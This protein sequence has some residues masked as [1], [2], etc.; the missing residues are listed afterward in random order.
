MPLVLLSLIV[1]VT[2][3]YGVGFY[4]SLFV[5]VSIP[6]ALSWFAR[7]DH[8]NWPLF[9]LACVAFLIGVYFSG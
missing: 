7:P 2:G 4:A 3:Y 9:M 6:V 1:A 5:L 8:A